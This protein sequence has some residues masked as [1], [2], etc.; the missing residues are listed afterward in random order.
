MWL[1]GRP[2]EKLLSVLLRWLNLLST[3]A[4]KDAVFILPSLLV[5]VPQG[6]VLEIRELYVMP[7]S[8]RCLVPGIPV[9]DNTDDTKL[10]V[11]FGC[12]NESSVNEVAKSLK[13]CRRIRM[14]TNKMKIY[15]SKL[16]Y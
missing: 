13:T 6:S 8:D 2:T 7:L 15:F 4:I 9:Q 11:A 16:K 12:E 14:N 1:D 5:G 10:C 3:V